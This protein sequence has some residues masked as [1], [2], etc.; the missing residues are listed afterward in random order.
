MGLSDMPEASRKN[1]FV[2]MNAIVWDKFVAKRLGAI[3][4]LRQINYVKE[5]LS[6]GKNMQDVLSYIRKEVP[7][8]HELLADSAREEKVEFIRKH[9]GYMLEEYLNQYNKV[10]S[11][12]SKDEIRKMMEL[13]T[14]AT[15]LLAQG[16]WDKIVTLFKIEPEAQ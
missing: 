7:N 9:Y 8:L 10:K 1:M 4:S 3:L 16:K 14:R 15:E 2:D 13:Y 12:K 5:M 6:E 11:E